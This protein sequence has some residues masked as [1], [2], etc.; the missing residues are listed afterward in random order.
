[1]KLNYQP[2]P[3]LRAKQSTASIMKDLTL[4]L[5]A[6]TVYAVIYYSNTFGS[7]YGLRVVLLMLDAIVTAL[8]TEAVFFKVMKKDIKTG[9][10]SSYG[11]VT[12]M[13]IVLITDISMSYYAVC[14]ATVIA[15]V[16]GK[17]V[18][19]GFGQNIF[20]PAAFGEAIIM[21]SFAAS[22]STD[23]V[24]GATPTIA[25][26]GA[27]WIFDSAQL[28][29]LVEPYSGLGGMFVGQY[30]STIGSTCALLL[31]LCAIFLIVR[32]DIDWQTPV[33][34]VG[35]VFVIALIVG[36]MHGASIDYAIFHV[37]AGGVL[38]G[39]IFMATDP[40]TTPVS[41]GGRVIYA[42]AA[43]SLTMII[44][45]KSNLSDG[46]LYAI[47]LMN[48][49][50]PA[51]ESMMDGNQ[52]KDA[53]KLR[54][55]TIITSLIFVAMA[56]GVG[57]TLQH[58]EVVA[59]EKT[60]AKE[61]KTV[62]I[63]LSDAFEENAVKVEEV[64]NDGKVAVYDCTAK[65]FGLID[66]DGMATASGHEYERNEATIT[67]NLETMT[68]ESIEV[69]SFGDT[70]GFGDKATK[71]EALATYEGKG[72]D[73]SV[74]GVSQATYTSTSIASMVHAALDAAQ[75]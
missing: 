47:L 18:F 75:Q 36:A 15:I 67:I 54:N 68:V 69:T 13:I 53:K 59:E 16:F 56:V 37:L 22:K 6:V 74:D 48:M 1:M 11:W 32:K 5:L 4:C 19:G 62:E 44:R 24:T 33:F 27:G 34:Y 51:I 3:S 28:A 2:S 40:V 66:P 31:I 61:T 41:L 35:S 20:N 46:V 42:V 64:S 72:I 63:V 43:A 70:A 26:K 12:A 9:L 29:K 65:G 7:A 39:G 38:F 71:P 21:N 49:L 30:P 57:A 17:L 55:K 8:V 45:T 25:A 14:V 52:I 50:T 58:K 73:D 23:F 10:K 60:D